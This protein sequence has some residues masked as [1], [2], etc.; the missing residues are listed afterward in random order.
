MEKPVLESITSVSKISTNQKALL[1]QQTVIVLFINT[2]SR[3][4]YSKFKQEKISNKSYKTNIMQASFTALSLV[5][6][7]ASNS[8]KISVKLCFRYA[9]QVKINNIQNT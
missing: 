3:Y 4:F 2:A 8:Y 9:F 1:I 7:P 5:F 6:S